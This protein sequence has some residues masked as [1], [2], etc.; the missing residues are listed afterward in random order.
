MRLYYNTLISNTIEP[1]CCL[2]W[3]QK[4]NDRIVWKNV[5]FKIQKIR[6]IKLKWFQICIVHRI[7]ATNIV[8]NKMRVVSTD[9]C[10]FCKEQ[11]D[12]IQHFLWGCQ[13][14]QRFW[15]DCEKVLNEKCPLAC[16]MKLNQNIVLFGTDLG[17][18][19]DSITDFI[20]VFAK[21]YIFKCKINNTFP[22][23]SNFIRELKHRYRVEEY[24]AKVS[25]NGETFCREWLFHTGIFDST[26]TS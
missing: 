11:R 6:D 2:K 23:I 24:N 21:Y 16:D 10:S 9:K 12:S 13:Y 15:L 1:N 5:F 25:G 7:I 20:I 18:R 22:N 14:V 4:L 26:E 17:F 8:L 3:N 19:T